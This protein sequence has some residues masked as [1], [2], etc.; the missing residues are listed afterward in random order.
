MTL[1]ILAGLAALILII[2]AGFKSANVEAKRTGR[3]DRDKKPVM[4]PEEERVIKVS[5]QLILDERMMSNRIKDPE[6]RKT[7]APALDKADD[8]LKVLQSN[9]KEIP[10]TK[11]FLNYYIPTLAAV[12]KKYIRLEAS[13]VDISAE[14]EK[15]KSYIADINKAMNRQYKNLFND[16]KLDLSVEMEAMALSFQR[17]GLITESEMKAAAEEIPQ[18]IELTL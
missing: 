4:T 10:G 2:V 13:G 14:T 7:L 8:I 9:P 12:L 17:D 16:D 11:Q 6:I 5:K 3:L 15:I 1:I 18:E